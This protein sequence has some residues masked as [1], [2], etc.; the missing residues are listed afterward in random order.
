MSDKKKYTFER[1][2]DLSDGHH[3]FKVMH[4]GK[5]VGFM[6]GHKKSGTVGCGAVDKDHNFDHV[7]DALEDHL[8]K[9]PELKLVKKENEILDTIKAKLEKAKKWVKEGDVVS[10]KEIHVDPQDRAVGGV[11]PTTHKQGQ[12]PAGIWGRR[13]GSKEYAKDIHLDAIDQLKNSPNPKLVK[14]GDLDWSELHKIGG[15]QGMAGSVNQTGGP[16][17]AS[18]IGFG[19]EEHSDKKED[20]KLID[21]KIKEHE[22]KKHTLE[23][24][25]A[26]HD[27][28]LGKAGE[29]DWS[30]LTG[31][32]D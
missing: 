21:Q 5:Q 28:M 27:K 29:L 25:Q 9:K 11:H 12:S 6:T 4:E 30:E 13:K 22:E 19:K 8:R 31:K 17:I 16:S 23:S 32:K 24:H 20:E 3:E 1:H 14:A 18:Q 26:E 10:E 2:K 15:G 7:C